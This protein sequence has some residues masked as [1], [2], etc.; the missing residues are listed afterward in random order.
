MMTSG[1]SC[2]SQLYTPIYELMTHCN[3]RTQVDIGILDFSNADTVPHLH[4]KRIK[5]DQLWTE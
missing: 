2:K 5:D 3:I 4:L 1:L